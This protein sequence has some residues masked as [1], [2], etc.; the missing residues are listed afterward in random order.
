VAAPARW[1]EAYDRL[2][3]SP[4]EEVRQKALTLA[5]LF[6]DPRALAKLRATAADGQGSTAGRQAALQTL[7]DKRAADL[8]PLLRDLL[9]EKALRATALRG[10]AA[11]SDPETPAAVLKVY[12]SLSNEE[13][14]VAVATL[15]TRPEFA[16]ALLDAMGRGEVQRSDL[17]PF[18]ARQLLAFN[19]SVL[20]EKL[21]STWGTLR[22]TSK[23][24]VAL[25]ARYKTVATPAALSKADRSHGRALFAKNCASCHTLFG[26][27]GKVG[28][29]LTGAQ[30]ANPEYILTKVLDP[31]A[32]VAKDYQLTQLNLKDGRSLT[33]IIKEETAKTLAVQT[34]TELLRLPKDEV[35]ERRKLD[36][37]MMPEGIL[38]TLADGEI[39]DLLAYL[40][41]VDQVPLPK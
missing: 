26:E 20:T 40:A 3:G 24:K 5:L 39:L 15:T 22:A 18:A 17:S 32:V 29:E 37:S 25:L 8:S 6:N 10:L 14:A 34:P 33:G 30:R 21:N 36:V 16:R 2:A 19:D 35:D 27:G 28:P 11:Y 4:D 7:V 31:N 13:K 41:G 12:G 23:D 38:A 9:K 1:A